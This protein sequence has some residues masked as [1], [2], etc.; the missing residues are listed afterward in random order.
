MIVRVLYFFVPGIIYIG[1]HANSVCNAHM[2]F[3]NVV[4]WSYDQSH[5][6]T[7]LVQHE[8]TIPNCDK[9]SAYNKCEAQNLHKV[10]TKIGI[11]WQLLKTLA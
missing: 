11:L 1:E 3:R 4:M 5:N 7:G 10:N 8:I 9:L 6:V 2:V